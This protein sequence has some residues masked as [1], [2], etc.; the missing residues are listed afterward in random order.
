M[1]AISSG[2]GKAI[3]VINLK[4]GVGKTHTTWLLAAICEERSRRLLLID[5]D[6]QANLTGSF[7][8]QPLGETGI[9]ALFHPGAEHDPQALVRRTRFPNIDL[10]PASSTLARFDL[11]DQKQWERADL[12]LS[13]VDSVEQLRTLY[14]YIIFDCPPRLSLVT[15]AALCASDHV[16]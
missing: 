2:Q 5:L 9:E 7:M 1:H 16:I 12:H 4:G 11:S 10:L 13:L 15:F 3:T 6:T 14:D 8:E